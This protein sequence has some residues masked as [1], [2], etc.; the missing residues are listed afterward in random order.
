MG[1]SHAAVS[2]SEVCLCWVNMTKGIPKAVSIDMPACAAV[3]KLL[4]IRAEDG[5]G[6]TEVLK[7]TNRGPVQHERSVEGWQAVL[8]ACC[9]N[10][11]DDG[12]ESH[13]CEER[14]R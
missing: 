14:A 3:S 11:R 9:C 7:L 1:R 10:A 5:T 12:D 4:C 13:R 6:G 8:M 2:V